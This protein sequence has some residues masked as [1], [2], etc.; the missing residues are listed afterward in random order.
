[1]RA[2]GAWHQV[3]RII[4]HMIDGT[5]GAGSAPGIPR[6]GPLLTTCLSIDNS[7]SDRISV[8]LLHCAACRH[9]VVSNAPMVCCDCVV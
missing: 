9:D 8:C 3:A 4:E 5:G 6:A 2:A 7:K 1:M